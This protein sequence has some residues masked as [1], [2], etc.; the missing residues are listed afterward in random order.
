[1][2]QSVEDRI[3]EGGI[4]DDFMPL[5]DR[6]LAGD[7]SGTAAMAILNNLQQVSSLLIG[8]GGKSPVIKDQEIALGQEGK[9]LGVASDS[10]GQGQLVEEP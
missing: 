2:N 10:P 7:Q 4:S 5:L 9:H 6:K 8:K 1:M 3:G